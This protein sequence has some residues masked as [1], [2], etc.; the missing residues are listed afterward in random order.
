MPRQADPNERRATIVEAAYG[1]LANQGL[2]VLSMRSVAKAVGVTTGMVT[3]WFASRDALLEAAIEIAA[4]REERRAREVVGTGADLAACMAA[5][6]PLDSERAD[7]V[8][9][10][11]GFW[12]AS[13]GNEVLLAS[14]RRRYRVWARQ[15]AKAGLVSDAQAAQRLIAIVDGISIDAVLDPECWPADEQLAALHATLSDAG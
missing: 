2:S 9:V 7:E 14:H 4:G 10:W 5:F 15:L 1:I 13:V 6:L 12:A 8:R 3:H 11:I